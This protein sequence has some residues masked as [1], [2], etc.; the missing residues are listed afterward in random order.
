MRPEPASM[1]QR[2]RYTSGGESDGYRRNERVVAMK[3][4]KDN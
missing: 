3:K 2:R 4:G 1:K